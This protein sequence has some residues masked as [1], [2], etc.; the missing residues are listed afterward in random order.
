VF[1]NGAYACGH[2]AA[3]LRFAKQRAFPSALLQTCSTASASWCSFP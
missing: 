3:G 1:N 2:F